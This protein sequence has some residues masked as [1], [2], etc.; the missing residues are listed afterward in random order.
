[1]ENTPLSVLY[2]DDETSLLDI[3]KLFLERLGRN[4]VDTAISARDALLLL[5]AGSYDAVISDY[6][7][8]G[9][10]GIELLKEVRIRFGDIPFILFTGRGREEIVIQAINHGADFYLQKGG[11][12]KSQFAELEHKL[13][14]A[15]ARRRAE[16]DL[17]ESERTS[18][19][20]LDATTDAVALMTC[21]LTIVSANEAF[22]QRFDQKPDQMPGKPLRDFISP[23]L[24]LDHVCRIETVISTKKP[25]RFEEK[26]GE[27]FLENSVYPI[28]DEQGEVVRL[29]GYCRDVTDKKQAEEDLRTAYEQIAAD[30]EELR[31]RYDE[32]SL[33][34]RQIR[35]RESWFRGLFDQAFQLAAVLDL[36]GRITHINQTALDLIGIERALVI[37]MPFWETPWWGHDTELQELVR[38]SISQASQGNM[39][40]F[41]ATHQDKDGNIRNID[42]SLKPLTDKAGSVIGLLPEGRDITYLK[43][44]ERDLVRSQEKFRSFYNHSPDAVFIHDSKG[45]ILDVNTTMCRMYRVSP[46]EAL[47]YTIQDYSGPD[48]DISE[49]YMHWERVL[50][51]E[52]QI[53]SWQARRPTDGSLFDVEVFLTRIDTDGEPL[54]LGNV[55][56]VTER[57]IA[58]AA[59]QKSEERYRSLVETTGTGYVVLDVHGRVLDAN[60]TYIRLTGRCCLDEIS[61]RSVNEWTAPYDLERNDEEVRKCIQNGYVRGLN[62]DYI[63]PDGTIQ[64]LEINASVVSSESGDIILTLCRDVSTKKNERNEC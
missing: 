15:V 1:M 46:D 48:R 5:T 14:Q 21:D 58:Q 34:E 29:A 51:G 11:E 43:R 35:E 17:R 2:V 47:T 44:V 50:S 8:P 62:L 9:M 20:L 7:M 57:N 45:M 4:R 10:D 23:E 33:S 18:R 24:S 19:A 36:D 25:V 28:F 61:G 63:H 6:Q 56:D 27:I 55:H 60:D 59:I 38:S 30:E 54:I 40:R 37:D 16:R 53:F 64:P 13:R 49:A 52:D 39:V 41:E 32:L 22:A 26:I 31:E 42:F 12:P 3:G